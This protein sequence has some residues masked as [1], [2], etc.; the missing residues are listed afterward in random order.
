VTA[1]VIALYATTGR[2]GDELC[3]GRVLT[4]AARRGREARI[5]A[6]CNSGWACASRSELLE[7]Q[8]PSMLVVSVTAWNRPTSS[9]LDGSILA[10]QSPSHARSG[11][12]RV[13]SEEG[14][15]A[16]CSWWAEG[17]AVPARPPRG[18]HVRLAA[19]PSQARAAGDGVPRFGRSC[20]GLI[21]RST[22][23]PAFYRG[24]FGADWADPWSTTSRSTAPAGPA[25]LSWTA[26]RQRFW[27]RRQAQPRDTG[28]AG[29][30]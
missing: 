9:R 29:I 16:T 22:P 3:G 4:L 30:V 11:P 7:Q 12:G 13:L 17:A 19:P 21:A 26:G 28:A 8:K 23:A 20:V 24:Y 25:A 5:P 18:R 2:T 14:S 15:R 6:P 1:G 10:K 27:E